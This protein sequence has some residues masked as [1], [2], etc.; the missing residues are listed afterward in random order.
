M[1]SES[2]SDIAKGRRWE[3]KRE[4]C[5]RFSLVG[6]RVMEVDGGKGCVVD[7][8][9]ATVHLIMA[10]FTTIKKEQEV[11]GGFGVR[12]VTSSSMRR[13]PACRGEERRTCGGKDGSGSDDG[14]HDDGALS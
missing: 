8:V 10:S 1:E 12:K 14:D 2:R 3:E 4:A 6:R 5:Q 11:T 7:V 13:M 9:N